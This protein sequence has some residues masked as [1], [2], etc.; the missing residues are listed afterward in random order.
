MPEMTATAPQYDVFISYTKL[1]QA[2][3][4]TVQH[5]LRAF[6]QRVFL[7]DDG[8]AAG[9]LWEPEIRKAATQVKTLILIWSRNATASAYIPQELRMIPKECVV[10]PIMLDGAALPEG[11]KD[12]HG[13]R[14][15]QVHE[16]ILARATSLTRQKLPRSRVV[17]QILEE[18]K[19]DGYD[20]LPEQR[21]AVALVVF[22]GMGGAT[23]G[24]WVLEWLR[25]RFRDLATSPIILGVTSSAA[26]LAFMGG[27]L[28]S[29]RANARDDDGS[30]SS[31]PA[32]MAA[33]S[34]AIQEGKVH[35]LTQSVNVCQQRLDASAQGLASCETVRDESIERHRT[36]EQKL[37][38]VK[39]D[40]VTSKRDLESQ[41]LASHTTA[42]EL[43]TVERN[44]VSCNG[45]L[46][47]AR[48]ATDAALQEATTCQQVRGTL[49][50]SVDK[51]IAA[52][53][54]MQRTAKAAM[55]ALLQ[56]RATK[57]Q[58]RETLV[59][60]NALD[61]ASSSTHLDALSPGP[62][63]DAGMLKS[64]PIERLAPG[65]EP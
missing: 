24:W 6:S 33:Q 23:L 61:T 16:R 17:A 14:G 35:E 58:P 52:R 27:Y 64:A 32:S 42:S 9:Q 54:G 65:N 7:D 25:S 60:N 28:L 46:Q 50:A 63:L 41:R 30:T 43:A 26:S 55:A 34:C 10:L 3:A 53:D 49:Q 37:D 22:R 18:L 5:L 36:L 38:W 40:L 20:L 48:Q 45:D 51:A 2:A 47:S 15:L 57:P 13:L 62:L 31:A 29:D 56:C 19:E 59:S 4:R 21:D 39:K 44:L 8:I 11:I 12:H 1:D